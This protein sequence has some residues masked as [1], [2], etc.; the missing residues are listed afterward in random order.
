MRLNITAGEAES[1]GH[2][3]HNDTLRA[4]ILFNDTIGCLPFSFVFC[5]YFMAFA[6]I[7]SYDTVCTARAIAPHIYILFSRPTSY[8]TSTYFAKAGGNR[9]G[10]A[11][12]RRRRKRHDR[13]GAGYHRDS[14]LAGR[15]SPRMVRRFRGRVPLLPRAWLH[16]RE[17]AHQTGSLYHVILTARST[18][19]VVAVQ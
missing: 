16:D 6:T 7:I 10:T 4:L 1:V 5:R 15:C 9:T 12:T 11:T 3:P 14:G 17:W 13:E 8:H 2:A 19:C 18:C